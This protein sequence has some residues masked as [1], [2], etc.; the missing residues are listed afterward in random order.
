VYLQALSL[1]KLGCFYLLA[2]NLHRDLHYCCV[3]HNVEE[4]KQELASN[5]APLYAI[6]DSN[7]PVREQRNNSEVGNEVG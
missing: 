2:S 3:Q 5:Q 6:Y 7:D 4:E 1:L